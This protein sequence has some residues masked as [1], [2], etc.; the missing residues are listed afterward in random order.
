MEENMSLIHI[1]KAIG[2]VLYSGGARALIPAPGHS[3]KDRSASLIIGK[4]GRVI[5]HSFGGSTPYEILDDLRSR[6]LIDRR[7][8]LTH[9]LSAVDAFQG[10]TPSQ[11]LQRV[12]DLWSEGRGLIGTPSAIYLKQHRAIGRDLAK[13]QS[14]RHHIN[15]PICAYNPDNR[16]QS[17][18]MSCIQSP[19][20]KLT[21]IEVT[22]LDND[23][24]RDQRLR[25]SRK[26]IGSVPAGSYIQLDWPKDALLVGEGVMTTLS[27][28]EYFQLPAFAPLGVHNMRTFRPPNGVRSVLI[29]ADRG[30]QGEGAAQILRSNLLSL[31][32]RTE[33]ALPPEPY[34]DFNEMAQAKLQ[35]RLKKRGG[36]VRV[37]GS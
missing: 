3:R 29:A 26:I 28:S 19:D 32:I 10:P 21:A 6:G 33:I 22:Y 1:V 2:G 17:A 34:Q 16:T 37:T 18:L 7:G 8:F 20:Q 13:I 11:K 27:A 4:T 15:F 14:L 23:S 36:Q 30:R 12:E 9:S 31:G 25:L 35:A 5:A 24:K